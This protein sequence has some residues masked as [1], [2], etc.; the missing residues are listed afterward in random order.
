M[1][2]KRKG[3][4]EVMV[5]TLL[6]T[7]IKNEKEMYSHHILSDDCLV[8]ALFSSKVVT[9]DCVIDQW[10]QLEQKYQ[11]MV[12]KPRRRAIK[13]RNFKKIHPFILLAYY[14][15][16]IREYNFHVKVVHGHLKAWSTYVRKVSYHRA[17]V[18]YLS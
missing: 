12:A 6:M 7:V 5:P 17:S 2:K 13:I 16:C 8:S 3:R 18:S 4:K 11:K 9:P 10:Y 15:V 1:G 14:L